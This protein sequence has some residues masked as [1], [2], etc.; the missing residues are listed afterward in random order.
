M[1]KLNKIYFDLENKFKQKPLKYYII[2][3]IITVII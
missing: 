2:L 3:L 1:G